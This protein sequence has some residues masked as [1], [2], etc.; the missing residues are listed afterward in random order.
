MLVIEEKKVHPLARGLWLIAGVS[1]AGG[2]L[3]AGLHASRLALP[4]LPWLD[5]PWMLALH[6]TLN[7]IGFSLAAVL[8][9]CRAGRGCC[10]GRA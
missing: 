4:P 3:L 9:W 8:A 1:L 2:M 6:G 5:L 10:C 7:A